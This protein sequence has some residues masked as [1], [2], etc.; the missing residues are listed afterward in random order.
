MAGSDDHTEEVVSPMGE[1]TFTWRQRAMQRSLWPFRA[2]S[3]S[4]IGI[5]R[6]AVAFV[7]TCHWRGIFSCFRLTLTYGP[8]PTGP[9]HSTL[10]GHLVGSTRAAGQLDRTQP[11]ISRRISLIEPELGAALLERVRDGIR[12]TGAGRAFFAIC[13]SGFSRTEC[14]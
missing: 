4:R 5:W 1:I 6:V 7:H 10:L 3:G 11:D 8:T 13:G 14:A 12:L 9:T 2:N